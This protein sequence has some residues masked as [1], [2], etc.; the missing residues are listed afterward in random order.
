MVAQWFRK[1]AELGHAHSQ[2]AIAELYYYGSGMKRQYKNAVHWYHQAAKQGHADAQ[3]D[4]GHCYIQ[5]IGVDQNLDKA[6]EYYQ[7]AVDSG[8]KDALLRLKNAKH[9]QEIMP[10]KPILKYALPSVVV[11]VILDIITGFFSRILG[12]YRGY[13]Y[14]N[15]I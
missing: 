10:T 7:K 4:L 8:H 9:L 5:G 3:Y 14:S 12:N 6:I 15:G 1:S 13:W 2:Y 11:G